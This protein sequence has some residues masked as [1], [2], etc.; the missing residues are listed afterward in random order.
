[1]NLSMCMIARDAARTIRAAL[2]SVRPWVDEMVVVDTG[3]RDDT[4]AIAAACGAYVS[5]FAWC[6]DFSAARNVSL[7]LARGAWIFWMDADDTIDV[8][9]GAALRS[10]ADHIHPSSTMGFVMQVLCPPTDGETQYGTSVAVDHVKLLRNLPTICFTGRI[11]E[12]VLPAIRKLGGDVTW[13]NIRVEHSGSDRSPEGRS[14]KQARD[15]RLLELELADDPDNSFVLFNHGMTLVDMGDDERAL[16]QLCRSLQLATADESH[17]AKIYAL[18][19]QA[20]AALGR[21]ATALKTCLQGLRA[22]PDDPE[23]LFRRGTLEE[24][25]GRFDAAEQAFRALLTRKPKRHFASVDQGIFGV[26]AWHNLAVLYERRGQNDAAAG[27]WRQV[28]ERDPT[29]KVAWWGLLSMVSSTAV[30]H[31]HAVHCSIP[32][33]HRFA[34]VRAVARACLEIE[35][36]RPSEAL[37][38]LELA[39]AAS[40]TAVELWEIACR[41][42][43]RCEAWETAESWLSKLIQLVPQDPSPPQNLAVA[44]LRRGRSADAVIA[45]RRSL[46]L[47]PNYEPALR[48][49]Q[50]AER[51][52]DAERA[53]HGAY[54]LPDSGG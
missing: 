36:G 34:D 8:T 45:V 51:A 17:V 23:L 28:I 12:Q 26:K 50:E 11:H 4:A 9:N 10:L 41:I 2:E 14:R 21:K 35:K 24:S 13:S 16:P 29:S 6:D 32:D 52:L 37:R 42:A 19:V 46:A 38:V 40:G 1:M 33:A 5:H 30:L 3:S 25:L 22:Y 54:E 20:Y 43:F 47:R 48:V 18:L 49:L 39:L 27:A 31:L 44:Y 15:L 53:A 7:R